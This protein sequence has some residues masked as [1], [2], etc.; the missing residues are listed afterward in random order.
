MS[1]SLGNQIDELY[2]QLLAGDERACRQLVDEIHTD[3][4]VSVLSLC[5]QLTQVFHSI[6]DAWECSKLS[7]YREHV[8]TQ[9]GHR[10]LLHLRGKLPPTQD[11]AP[12][13][14][15]CTPEF[16]PYTLPSLMVELA[17]HELGWAATSL[18]SDLPLE[19]LGP[20]IDDMRPSICW[21][22]VSYIQ[23]ADR[24]R[25]Q[26]RY[27]GEKGRDSGV[28]VVCGGQA[29]NDEI[30]DGISEVTFVDQLRDLQRVVTSDH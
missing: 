20:A 1:A 10:L 28:Q 29:L 14:I 24:L 17:M 11:S 3:D 30:R 2:R 9:I 7:V 13:A 6:G 19:L 21:I 18:G 15:G 26:L 4:N 5:E 27:V 8:A 22:S 12:V 25:Q 23:S 16:D